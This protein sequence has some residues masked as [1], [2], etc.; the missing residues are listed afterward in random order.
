MKMKNTGGFFRRRF[1]FGPMLLVFLFLWGCHP[2]LR[3]EVTRPEDALTRVRFFYPEFRD[4]M[5]LA[6]LENAVNHSLAYLS[7]QSPDQ[8]F[9]YGRDKYS[10]RQ[11]V[12]S[13][14][15]L[16][17]LIRTSKSSE[18]FKRA[19]KKGFILYRAK[20][21]PQN[22]KVLFTGYYEPT[23]PASLS[24]DATYKHPIY[25]KPD[26]LIQVDLSPFREEFKG[27]SIVA[28]IDGKRVV[29]Y[30]S[31]KEI[32]DNKSLA[33]RRLEIAWLKDHLDVSFLQ[34]QGS[35]RLKLPDNSIM[36]VGYEA[37]NGRP[38]QSI[39]RY[40]LQKGLLSREE[41]SMQS[42][43]RYLAE[44]REA[45]PEILNY[46]PSYVFFRTVDGGP[47]GSINVPLTPGRSLALDSGLFPKGALCFVTTKKPVL[48]SKSGIA[49]WNEFSRFMLNQDTGG[50]IKGAGRADLFWGSDDYAEIAAGHMKHEGDLYVLI[51]K[52]D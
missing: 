37:S 21:A 51:K 39:G 29:P 36:R 33:G 46:N 44:H 14:K 26:D 13:H 10:C 8:V 7:R 6:S 18:E 28:R 43:R 40:M 30:Y 9:E 17:N 12:E 38:Y 11:V 2:S 15:A 27:K 47:F 3:K 5:D 41:V 24:P 52:P 45:Q 49:G 50:A 31:R 42:I 23:Y 35:G 32:E 34:I 22:E 4:D 19:V 16:L 48:D 25:K 20:G 1:L